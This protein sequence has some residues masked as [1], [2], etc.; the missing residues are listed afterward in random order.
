MDYDAVRAEQAGARR[1]PVTKP[2]LGIGLSCWLE[3]AGFGPNGSLEGF[4]HLASWES[5]QVRIQP[6]GSAIIFA[7]SS[8]HGQGHETVFAQIAS[9]ELGHLVRPHRGAHR[10]HR[11]GAAG[12][13]HDGIA[14][15]ARRAG[16]P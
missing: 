8:P 2:L 7:G 15:R 11:D 10:R 1:R 12:H 4:G 16:R 6:D 3:I 14:G 9:D 5:A 13:R